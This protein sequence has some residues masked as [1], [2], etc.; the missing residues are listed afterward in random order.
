MRDRS[1]DRFQNGIP[2]ASCVSPDQAFQLATYQQV[3]TQAIQILQQASAASQTSVS[4]GAEGH[5]SR[6]GLS[7]QAVH[8]LQPQA[9]AVSGSTAKKSSAPGSSV[10]TVVT[11]L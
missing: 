5:G 7:E 1:A 3:K 11:T 4:D 6:D 10:L 9:L 8:A 2:P